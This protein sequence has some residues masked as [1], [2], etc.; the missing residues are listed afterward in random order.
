MTT[1]N[2]NQVLELVEPIVQENGLNTNV[3]ANMGSTLNVTGL[4]T[5]SGGTVQTGAAVRKYTPV[6]ANITA[7]LTAAQVAAGYITSTSGAAVT[8]TLPTGTL[9][10][11]AVGAV[12]GTTLELYI[13]N[14]AG[15]NTVTMAVAVNGVLDALAVA[16]AASFGLLTIPTGVT[17]VGRFTL[18]FSSATAYAF[19]R[20]A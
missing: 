12:Q 10:G 5:F 14:T 19:S 16:N 17:G 3:P 4:A 7:T 11:A 2:T 6:A 20:T 13:D 9:L 15:A 1:V 8:L 18:I